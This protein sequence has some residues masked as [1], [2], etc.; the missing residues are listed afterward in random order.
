MVVALMSIEPD[1]IMSVPAEVRK[2]GANAA[3]VLAVV[4][5]AT[6]LDGARNGRVRIGAVTWWFASHKEIG[7]AVGLNHDQVRRAVTKL[8]A[9]DALLSTEVAA[10]DRTRAYCVPKQRG[11]ENASP[12]TSDD[13]KT[14]DPYAKTRLGLREN[15]SS[16]STGELEKVSTEEGGEAREPAHTPTP[17]VSAY[18]PSMEE[19]T[20]GGITPP[21]RYCGKHQPSGT[22]DPCGRCADCRIHRD[23]WEHT[24]AGIAY[25]IR[26]RARKPSTVDDKALGWQAQKT[27]DGITRHLKVIDGEASA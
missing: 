12:L 4:R 22:S 20:L 15:A 9:E 26:R 18:P 2:Y 10:D 13:A 16:T 6:S 3:L 1:F 27:H 23:S 5:Y 17:L 19:P 21:S 11:R 24:D 7:S 14:P 8:E 25:G